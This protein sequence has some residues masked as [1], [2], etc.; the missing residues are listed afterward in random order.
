MTP[1]PGDA[2][3]PGVGAGAVGAAPSAGRA[4]SAARPEDDAELQPRRESDSAVRTPGHDD[5]AARAAGEGDAE[6]PSRG[7]NDSEARAPGDDDSEARALREGDAEVQSRPDEDG[8]ARARRQRWTLCA[9]LLLTFALALR[10]FFAA[11]PET[12]PIAPVPELGDGAGRLLYGLPLDL[13]RAPEQALYALPRIGPS[14]AAAIVAGRP[15]CEVGDLLEVHGIGPKT[16]AGL[17]G[18][19]EVAK[20]PGVCPSQRGESATAASTDIGAPPG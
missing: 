8:E 13:N 12:P 20:P 14:L 7:N 9:A 17:R 1:P 19:V 2:D 3:A 15:Y 4:T 18:R 6:A 5:S 11:P 16:L 10:T